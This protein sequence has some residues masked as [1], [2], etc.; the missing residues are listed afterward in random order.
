MQTTT[1]LFDLDGTLLPMDQEAFV[2]AYL[3]PLAARMAP[4]GYDPTEMINALWAGTDAMVK[5]DG[6][7]RNEEVFWDIFAGVFGERVRQDQ[8][9]FDEFYRTDFQNARPAC[10]FAPQAASTVRKLKELGFRVV[11]ATN[12]IFPAVA[13]E[14]RIRW[15]GLEPEEFELVTT[16]ENSRHCKPNTAYYQD[17]IEQ[18][19]VAAE[20]CLMVGND[21]EEDMIARTIGMKVFLLPA[22]LINRSGTDINTFPH[23]D[24]DDLLNYAEGL[25]TEE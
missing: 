13:T 14:S 2:K 5:N 18:I 4:M 8:P 23:G 16:Y 22:G 24:F 3:G 25:N 12:P 10:G 17:I 20:E 15:A 7:R 1:I 19:G 11:L 9:L 6:S 21:V